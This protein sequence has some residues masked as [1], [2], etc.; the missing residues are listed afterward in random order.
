VSAALTIP[1]ERQFNGIRVPL[2][3][4]QKRL[5]RLVEESPATWIGYGGSRG[6][7]KSHGARAVMLIR[8]FNHPG[9]RG[10]IIRRKYKELLENHIEPLFRQFPQMR[11]WYN[12]SE[13][14]LKLPN[15]SAV[16]FGYAEHGGDIYDFQGDEFMDI[17]VDEAT[18]FKEKDLI[19]LKTCNRW[20]GMPDGVCKMVLTCN[21]GNVGHAFVKRTFIDSQYHENESASD[22]AF[23]QACGWDNVGWAESALAGDG[24]TAKDYYGWTDEQ[25]FKYFVERTDYGKRLN[26]LPGAMRIG[27]LMGRWDQFA[28]QFFDC[29]DVARHTRAPQEIE[30]KPW[31]PRWISGDWGYSHPAAV[32]WHAQDGDRVITYDELH[33]SG[34]GERE[35]G[36]RIVAISN[37]YKDS[38]GKPIKIQSVFFDQYA[39][40]KRTSENTIAE[41]IGEVLAA[42]GLP[43][44]TLAD[45][46]RIGGGRLC[47]EMLK[48]DLV[49]I[50]TAC[51]QLIECLPT[52]SHDEDNLEDVLKV[53]GDDPYDA[54]RY[55]LKSM[56]GEASKPAGVRIEEKIE[57]WKGSGQLTDPTSEMIWRATLAKQMQQRAQPVKMGRRRRL[58]NTNPWQ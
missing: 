26:S 28:G 38:T 45:D 11:A 29:F 30:L 41:Q 16:V 13:K 5:L 35:L 7:G 37:R 58:G 23:L 55:G 2:Q 54:W 34:I 27:H 21:P 24:L 10:L 25:R 47:Y 46:D 15:G 32:Y 36:E 9:T 39:F 19:F 6:G 3:P 48:A 57:A 51:P 49:V 40:A 31:W 42:N 50:S 53:D 18:H 12:I 1:R 52:L 17:V 8:R 43:M 4:K 22:Y 56:L 44:P 14:T 33:G 20:T